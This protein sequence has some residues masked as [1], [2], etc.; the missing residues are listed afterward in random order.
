MTPLGRLL[1]GM[2]L[3]RNMSELKVARRCGFEIDK[4][5]EFEKD[6]G[7]VPGTNLA[8]IFEAIDI[9]P[10][11]YADFSMVAYLMYNP[12]ARERRGEG[13]VESKFSSVDSNNILSRLREDNADGVLDFVKRSGIRKN[14]KKKEEEG[15]L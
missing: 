2:R 7:K 8:K 6:P 14:N 4:Y 3:N 15:E 13:N 10:D 5:N 9:T 12:K 1:R 11:E